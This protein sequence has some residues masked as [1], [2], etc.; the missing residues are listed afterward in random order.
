M[1][2]P[3]ALSVLFVAL[4]A[5]GCGA[6]VHGAYSGGGANAALMD[7]ATVF[8][9]LVSATGARSVDTAILG[10]GVS[11][12]SE[13]SGSAQTRL[14]LERVEHELLSMGFEVVSDPAEARLRA[15]FSI[16]AVRYD[17]LTG[18]IADEARLVFRDSASGRVIASYYAETRWITPTVKTLVKRLM[19]EV[20]KSQ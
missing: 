7:S 20:R 9:S 18:W 3:T 12:T 1:S 17:P 11:S 14:A 15:E 5:S 10:S 16:G 13:K 8:V 6:S 2:T 4:L 19:G